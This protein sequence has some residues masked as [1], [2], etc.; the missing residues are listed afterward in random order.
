MIRRHRPPSLL[1]SVCMHKTIQSIA[2]GANDYDA[3]S[4][5]WPLITDSVDYRQKQKLN[6][7]LK[8]WQL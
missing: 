5:R 6:A 7:R 2:Y 8:R 1:P 3:W 4:V